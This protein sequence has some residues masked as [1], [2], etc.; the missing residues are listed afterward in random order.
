MFQRLYVG[1]LLDVGFEFRDGGV[2]C[3]SGNT[4]CPVIYINDYSSVLSV[5]NFVY[6][7]TFE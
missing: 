2:F 5:G 1:L 7:M 3:Q 4:L 6:F